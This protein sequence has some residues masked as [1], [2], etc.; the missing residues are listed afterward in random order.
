M[1]AQV[2]A[3]LRAAAGVGS[4]AREPAAGCDFPH[5][6][7]QPSRRRQEGGVFSRWRA[8]RSDGDLKRCLEAIRGKVLP[9][10]KDRGM[11]GVEGTSCGH[12]KMTERRRRRGRQVRA[13][14]A[15]CDKY[16][17]DDVGCRPAKRTRRVQ[18]LLG[19]GA[20]KAASP[21]PSGTDSVGC[22]GDRHSDTRKHARPCLRQVEEEVVST[23]VACVDST[24]FSGGR[25]SAERRRVQQCIGHVQE[26]T[27]SAHCTDVTGAEGFQCR[28]AQGTKRER[29]RLRR[30]Q[31]EVVSPQTSCP[32]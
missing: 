8:C 13:V 6:R 29:Q 1:Q 2:A 7:R 3:A 25:Y 22:I 18:Q 24:G 27:A 15:K 28:H 31:E 26:E 4:M 17:G 16:G 5:G 20:E 32:T 14:A 9:G 23:D 12:E 19:Q 21:H 30:V 10:R 11:D